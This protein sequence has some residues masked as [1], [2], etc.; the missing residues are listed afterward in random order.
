MQAKLAEY[1]FR[2]LSLF[3]LSFAHRIGSVVGTIAYALPNNLKHPLKV[4]ID[5]CFPNISETERAELRKRSF[6][7]MCKGLA[8]VGAIFTM[9]RQRIQKL[10]KQ[11]SGEEHLEEGIK[12]GNGII[13]ALPHLGCWEILSFYLPKYSLHTAMYR[14]LRQAGL[15]PFVKQSRERFGTT[16]VPTD[17]SGVRSLYKALNNNKIIAILPD[18]DPGTEGNVFAPFFNTT[19]STMTLLPRLAKKTGA[20]IIY[21]YAERLAHGKGF[22]L[23]F[24]AEH[25]DFKH[26]DLKDAASSMNEGIES[27]IRQQPEQYLWA[28]KRF[29]TRPEG[30]ASLYK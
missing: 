26:L 27:C 22:H 6:I 29:K 4:N 9:S 19:A 15:N 2:F 21:A 25:R 14:P 20:T 30:E 28:Y 10:V 23:H 3:P 12:K 7:E 11:V 24:Q 17:A 16:L 18:Q 5:L 13:L 8:E 1:F